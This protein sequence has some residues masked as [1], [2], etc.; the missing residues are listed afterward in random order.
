MSE[1]RAGRTI[2]GRVPFST[3]W[4]CKC[5]RVQAAHIEECAHC[6]MRHPPE[7]YWPHDEQQQMFRL[8]WDE[9]VA[10][11]KVR[12]DALKRFAEYE[13]A[14]GRRGEL[15]ELYERLIE[16]DME[17]ARRRKEEEL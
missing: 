17:V 11:Q 12:K 5:G 13:A 15:Y 16:V 1:E 10:V 14:P 9:I 4:R 6:G 7:S 2:G 3:T 8:N